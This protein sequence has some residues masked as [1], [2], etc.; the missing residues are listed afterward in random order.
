MAPS[1]SRPE[2]TV[3]RTELLVGGSDREFRSLVQ[4]L[5]GLAAGIQAVTA[6]FA[7]MIGLSPPQYS[8]VVSVRHLEGPQPVG[9]T[10]LARFLRLSPPFV[11]MEVAKLVRMGLLRKEADSKDGRRVNL[12][13][14]PKGRER[15]AKLAPDQAQVN[16]L[17]FQNFSAQDFRELRRL[18]AKLAPGSERG[19]ALLAYMTGDRELTA[20]V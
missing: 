20:A 16:D 9:I 4:E 3:N 5:F 8:I 6:G 19:I 15:L 13:L 10:K 14:T 18:L 7:A 17:I 2:R 11:A 12:T 1:A